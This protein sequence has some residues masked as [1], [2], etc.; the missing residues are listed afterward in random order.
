MM[1][2]LLTL[3]SPIIGGFIY[4][5]ERVVKARMQSRQGPPV[6]QP[7]Y[8][9]VK[10]M[11]KR[12]MM[13][14]SFHASMGIM[15]FI[16]TWFAMAVLMM[17]ND[18]LIAIFFHVISVL[19]LTIGAFSVRSSYSIMGAMRELMHVVSYEPVVILLAVSLYLVT[20]SFDI[21]K[22][23]TSDITP[24]FSLPLVFISF[25]GV[26]PMLLH[27]SP[28]DIAEAH[29]EIVGGPDI[30]YSGPFYEAVYTARWIEYV[31]VYF[32]VFLFGGSNYF[33]GTFL[34]VFSFIFINAVDN[35]TARLDYKKMLKF[36]WF[37][38]IPLSMLNI[39][40]VVVGAN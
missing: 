7:F 12:P 17:G 10:L 23:L 26:M 22:I 11:Q 31:Y 3:F 19:A 6:L 38:L 29:Q 32:I 35:S 36:A 8:D 20:G 33:L 16:S 24:I 2:L 14:H 21:A 25:L 30:E 15:Y 18:L 4:G 40:F 13:V 27:K 37:I 9:F 1:G 34:V 39:F 28:F 5:V